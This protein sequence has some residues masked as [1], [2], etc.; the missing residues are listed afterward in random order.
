MLTR[1]VLI[2]A[3]LFLTNLTDAGLG[4][5]DLTRVNLVDADLTRAVLID[6]VLTEAAL[7]ARVPVP[8][9]WKRDAGSGRLVELRTDPG[10]MEA[11]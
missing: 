9:G 5:A 1:A 3:M 2:G 7:S 6:A 10:P 11:N 8:S 4:G